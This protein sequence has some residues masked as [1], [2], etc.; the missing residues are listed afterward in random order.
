MMEKRRLKLCINTYRKI[1]GANLTFWKGEKQHER[2]RKNSKNSIN[3]E[4]FKFETKTTDNID[5][6]NYS[7]Y[8]MRF[9]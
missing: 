8:L 3:S 5:K 7:V 9:C 6:L 2:N 4:Y 1:K